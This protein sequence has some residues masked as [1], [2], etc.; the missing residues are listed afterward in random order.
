[1]YVEWR[2]RWA[3]EEGTKYNHDIHHLKQMHKTTWEWD[4][5]AALAIRLIK[6]M[7]RSF[8][9]S[10]WCCF[11]NM[12]CSMHKTEFYE[13]TASSIDC[14]QRIS[15]SSTRHDWSILRSN[16]KCS[17]LAASW[18]RQDYC[19][20]EAGRIP[21]RSNLSSFRIWANPSILLFLFLSSVDCV[22]SVARETICYFSA[23]SRWLIR[24]VWQ[25]SPWLEGS[26]SV[27]W[28]VEKLRTQR[29]SCSGSCSKSFE[30]AL[31]AIPSVFFVSLL[32]L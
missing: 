19:W 12:N 29:T 4:L 3:D 13:C 9:F 17:H 5:P 26:W 27:G 8:I 15:K 14:M 16:W 18:L 1:M 7:W 22:T 30:E 23:L 6:R 32:D 25:D 21:S 28:S 2:S 24:G 11:S 31:F 10:Q 20:M